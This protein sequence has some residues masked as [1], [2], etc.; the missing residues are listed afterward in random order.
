MFVLGLTGSIGMGKTTAANYFR[1]LRVPVYNS[2]IAVHS[3]L[4][5][6]GEAVTGVAEKFGGVLKGN[7]ID[8]NALGKQVFNNQDKLD[9]L[10]SILHPL[11]R[12]KQK[13]FLVKSAIRKENLV[14]LEVPLLFETDGDKFCNAVAVVSAPN[15]IQEHRV[16]SRKGMTKKKFNGIMRRQ[17]PDIEKVRLG[18]FVIPTGL[19]KRSTYRTILG[20]LEEIGFPKRQKLYF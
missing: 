20:I 3:L 12:L 7:R 13:R 1:I 18:D 5:P 6:G 9:L 11:V 19:G 17:M 14:V 4:E 16:M 15:F 8:R 2:D 10:E